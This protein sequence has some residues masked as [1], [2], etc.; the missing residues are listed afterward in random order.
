MQDFSAKKRKKSGAFYRFFGTTVNRSVPRDQNHNLLL[1]IFTKYR[2]RAQAEQ[3]IYDTFIDVLKSRFRVIMRNL[4]EKSKQQ[5]KDAER[6]VPAKGYD[7]ATLLKFPPDGFPLEKWQRM[8]AHWNTEKWQKKSEAGRS[9][10]KNDLCIHTGG[11]IR[12]DQHRVNM[13]KENGKSVGYLKVFLQT[14]ATKEC[15]K[16]LKDGEITEKDYDQLKFVTERARRSYVSSLLSF[17]YKITTFVLY[18]YTK[19]HLV[20]YIFKIDEFYT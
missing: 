2:W 7:I 8:C 1:F 11:S 20:S 18:L 14:H 12:F 17:I 13:D 16:M 10:R 9:N 6:E 19:F 15:K 3:A 4:R 5:A